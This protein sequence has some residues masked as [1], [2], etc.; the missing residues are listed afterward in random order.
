MDGWRRGREQE[1]AMEPELQQANLYQAKSASEYEQMACIVKSTVDE[2]GKVYGEPHHSH[3]NI[4]LA[5]T[6][7]IQQ[8]YG[9][10]L[11][12]P[13]PHWLVE[14]MMV[15]FKVHRSARV[16]H[17]DNYIDANAYL[18]FAEHGQQNQN[19]PFNND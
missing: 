10:V 7:L 1:L 15:Q 3:K 12:H 11:D 17:A 13:L 18:R 6:G 9:I 8:H 5:W 19:E 2:R 14:Q 16:F 4:G